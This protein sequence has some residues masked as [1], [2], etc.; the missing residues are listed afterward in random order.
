MPQVIAPTCSQVLQRTAEL[1]KGPSEGAGEATVRDLRLLLRDLVTC[2]KA[3]SGQ[4]QQRKTSSCSS[5]QLGNVKA[6]EVG[7]NS[8]ATFVL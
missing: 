7:D 5:P 1:C 8:H 4:Q 3:Q 6:A 2:V